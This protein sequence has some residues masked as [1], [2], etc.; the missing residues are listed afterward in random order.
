MPFKIVQTLERGRT[1]LS[2]VPRTWETANVLLWPRKG[3]KKL[4]KNENSIPGE[5]WISTYCQLKRSDL[6]Y[7][8]AQTEL[9]RM[10]RESD[11]EEECLPR[12]RREMNIADMNDVA[13]Q[14][15]AVRFYLYY[16]INNR[17]SPSI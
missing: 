6:S 12:K 13:R 4:Q 8:E 11:T 15:L 10:Q 2:C 16:L 1:F 9:V 3:S 5:D 17:V 7:E 14:C